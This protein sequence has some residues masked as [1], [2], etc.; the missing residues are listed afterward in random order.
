MVSFLSSEVMGCWEIVS[1]CARLDIRKNLFMERV[2]RHWNGLPWEVVESSALEEC[3]RCVGIL[4]LRAL[5]QQSSVCNSHVRL[6]ACFSKAL[7]QV[8]VA[9]PCKSWKELSL[10]Y[11]FT[12]CLCKSARKETCQIASVITGHVVL[13]VSPGAPL[14]LCTPFT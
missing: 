1:S 7:Q 14:G 9:A 13:A 5:Q 10:S 8:K 3:Q 11:P 4:E 2:A 12:S 6:P